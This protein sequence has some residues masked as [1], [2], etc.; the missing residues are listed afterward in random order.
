M[1]KEGL[2]VAIGVGA[3]ILS[4]FALVA[5]DFKNKADCRALMKDKPAAEI[6][7]VCG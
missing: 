5:Y 2:L 7:V 4:C 3:L 6:K 1:D